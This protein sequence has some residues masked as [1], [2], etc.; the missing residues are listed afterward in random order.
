[1]YG[2]NGSFSSFIGNNNFCSCGFG[3]SSCSYI[4]AVGGT[5]GGGSVCDPT[6][7]SSGQY[8]FT[9]T[10]GWEITMTQS[11]GNGSPYRAFAYIPFCGG[12][13]MS[14][15]WTNP[16]TFY[17]SF[18]TN[19]LAGWARYCKLLFWTDAGDILGLLPPGAAGAV[20]A[21]NPYYSLIFFPSTDYPNSWQSAITIQ[22]GVWYNVAVT[23]NSGGGSTTNVQVNVTGYPGVSGSINVDILTDSNGPQLGFYNFHFGDNAQT[24][25]TAGLYLRNL[26]LLPP[27]TS[28]TP[29]TEPSSSSSSSNPAGGSFSILSS[30]ST[31]VSLGASSACPSDLKYTSG[32]I[33]GTFFGT[34]LI[35]LLGFGLFLFFYVRPRLAGQTNGATK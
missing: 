10:N 11:E 6:A 1:L 9:A 35:L 5:S 21:G 27:G 17:F 34:F 8:S 32:D 12:S 2:W 7:C 29:P 31:G 25:A 3:P 24:S 33:A 16:M 15:C 26:A 22:D 23:F 4:C 18:M 28:Y 14:T 30:S 13:Q 20:Q 19:G